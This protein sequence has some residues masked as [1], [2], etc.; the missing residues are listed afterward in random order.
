MN[1]YVLR[2]K[3]EIS[4]DDTKT[5]IVRAESARDA[6]KI[7]ANST[8]RIGLNKSDFLD[9]T[10]TSCRRLSS[11]GKAEVICADTNWG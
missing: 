4:Y 11:A 3:H 8:G 1:L 6:R 2:V 10:K 7:V 9:V 5:I